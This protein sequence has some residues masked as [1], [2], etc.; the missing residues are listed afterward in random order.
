MIG[1]PGGMMTGGDCLREAVVL[2]AAGVLE[3][4]VVLCADGPEP[5]LLDEKNDLLP[6][7]DE[8]LLCEELELLREELELLCEELE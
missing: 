8:E 7:P 3:W 2:P 1:R 6:D 4:E 5:D